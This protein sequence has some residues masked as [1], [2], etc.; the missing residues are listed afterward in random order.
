MISYLHQ[1]KKT[2]GN[3]ARRPGSEGD[4]RQARDDCGGKQIGIKVNKTLFCQIKP[5]EKDCIIE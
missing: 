2:L 1:K 5:R 3:H 4:P